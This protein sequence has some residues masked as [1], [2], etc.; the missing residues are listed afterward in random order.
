[1]I[2]WRAEKSGSR[3][4]RCTFSL[5]TQFLPNARNTACTAMGDVAVEVDLTTVFVDS[6]AV[7]FSCVAGCDEALAL[8][9]HVGGSHLLALHGGTGLAPIDSITRLKS[10]A[11]GRVVTECVVWKMRD[12]PRCGVA[13]INRA[14]NAIVRVHR[15][16]THTSRFGDTGFLTVAC[17]AIV[18]CKRV[19]SCLASTRH[20]HIAHGTDI[21]VFA[22][23]TVIGENTPGIRLTTIVRTRV[24]IVAL[25][26]RPAFAISV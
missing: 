8:A 3:H 4:V 12:V 6:V 13:E 9:S 26:T 17:I 10:V 19:A 23:S 11:E 21:S 20:A 22:R 1:M 5:E 7:L 2:A 15:G 18:A 24:T 14:V 16:S 25:K